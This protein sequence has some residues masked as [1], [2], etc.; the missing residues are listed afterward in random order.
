[1]RYFRARKCGHGWLEAACNGQFAQSLNQTI[2]TANEQCM[3]RNAYFL[4]LRVFYSWN[5]DQLVIRRTYASIFDIDVWFQIRDQFWVFHWKVH[6]VYFWIFCT[7]WFFLLMF[8][9]TVS[10]VELKKLIIYWVKLSYVHY[11]RIT[12]SFLHFLMFFQEI[13]VSY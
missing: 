4:C 1:M 9:V 13:V 8:F 7:F 12:S 5:S 10:R 11:R 3:V 6:R 2:L